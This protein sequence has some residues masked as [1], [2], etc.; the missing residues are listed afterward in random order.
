M[1]EIRLL[2]YYVAV[3]ETEHIGRASKALHVSQSP[4]SRQIRQLEEATALT[5]FEREKQRL[6]ITSEGK[7]LLGRARHILAQVH[8]LERDA[9]RLSRGETGTLRIGFV[10]TA[11]WS[12]L[13]PQALRAFRAKHSEVDIELKN[14][15]PA[16]QLRAVSRGE[17]DIA[18]VHESPT[19]PALSC[20]SLKE[21]ALCLVLPAEH[22]LAARRQIAP[23]DLEGAD[24]IALRT[25]RREHR[26]NEALLAACAKRGFVPN[27]RFTV[28]DQDTMVGLVA[29]GMGFAFSPESVDTSRIGGVA[30]RR[31]PWL[32]LTRGLRAVTRA[33]N[34]T[35]ITQEFVGCLK[36]VV[37]T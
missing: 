17:I 28:N 23:R 8:A 25:A 18:F 35:A 2:R 31:L 13:L 11:M 5:L 20:L 32:K 16:A 33:T 7:W 1:L 29:A 22:A 30:L 19:D 26:R 4:L 24:W 15:R 21:E 12:T 34:V 37:A 3:A 10:K 27:I 36:E 9:A 14:A 6:R